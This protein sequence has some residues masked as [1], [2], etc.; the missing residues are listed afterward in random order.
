MLPIDDQLSILVHLSLADHYMAEEEIQMIQKI[1]KASGLSDEHIET[2]VDNPKPVPRVKNLPTDEKFEYLFNVI[3]LM[4]VDG[5]IH[6]N[7]IMFCEKL[8]VALGYKPNVVAK[9]S[10]YIYKDPGVSTNS[11]FLRELA[12]KF[13]IK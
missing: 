5:K 7:E 6:Q 1:G 8:A 12:E 2:I 3:Q 10:A 4:K 11:L 13:L 9:L